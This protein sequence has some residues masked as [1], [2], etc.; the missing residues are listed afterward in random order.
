MMVVPAWGL[1]IHA[2][3]S[4]PA[5][6]E[7]GAA[8]A[9]TTTVDPLRDT[10]GAVGGSMALMA[11][12]SPPAETP[13]GHL[14]TAGKRRLSTARRVELWVVTVTAAMAKCPPGSARST[15]STSP[16]GGGE[17]VATWGAPTA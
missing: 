11:A 16:A 7:V 10:T 9:D 6:C 5:V 8:V 15:A 14:T 4:M 3:R 12:A 13:A 17:T 2:A 1:K